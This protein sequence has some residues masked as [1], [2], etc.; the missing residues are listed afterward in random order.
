MGV[1]TVAKLTEERRELQ[2][3]PFGLGTIGFWPEK[4]SFLLALLGKRKGGLQCRLGYSWRDYG[5]LLD[6]DLPMF[7][8]WM[9]SIWGLMLM[10]FSLWWFSPSCGRL[11]SKAD[12]FAFMGQGAARAA[13]VSCLL[14]CGRFARAR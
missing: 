7:R 12:W 13:P 2:I 9:P 4:Y 3:E 14:F 11:I 10:V 1:V 5:Y 6:Y 8:E